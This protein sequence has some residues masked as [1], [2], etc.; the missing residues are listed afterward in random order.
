MGAREVVPLRLRHSRTV[1]LMNRFSQLPKWQQELIRE[2]ME[3][4]FDNRIKVME[5]I[6]TAKRNH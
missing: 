3:T 2:D 1:D 4:A 6:N 5:R